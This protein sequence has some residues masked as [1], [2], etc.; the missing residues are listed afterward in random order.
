MWKQF[1]EWAKLLFLL[2]QETRQIRADVSEMQRELE[3][4]TAAVRDLAYEL[5]RNKENEMHE[6][7]KLLLK[8]ENDLL[9]F[10]RRLTSGRAKDEE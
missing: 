1:Y 9:R 10:E 6:R 4:L 7:D 8:L 3:E 2:A 5:R